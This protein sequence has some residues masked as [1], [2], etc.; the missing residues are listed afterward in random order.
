MAEVA[1]HTVVELRINEQLYEIL[2]VPRTYV[3]SCSCQAESTLAESFNP[4]LANVYIYLG[5]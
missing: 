5:T 3:V 2:S 4:Y 1:A